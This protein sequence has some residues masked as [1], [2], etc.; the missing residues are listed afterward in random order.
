MTETFCW[1][2][3]WYNYWH[4]TLTVSAR[5]W[6]PRS[7]PMIIFSVM[8]W[9]GWRNLSKPDQAMVTEKGSRYTL[10]HCKNKESNMEQHWQ[11]EMPCTWLSFSDSFCLTP[12]TA[13]LP[14]S[15]LLLR[16]RSNATAHALIAMILIS[17][18]KFWFQYERETLLIFLLELFLY[19][20]VLL[21]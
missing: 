16:T 5:P 21:T 13:L 8:K 11:W 12:S 2:L 7:A 10:N 3:T 19:S 17:S 4:F 9:S 15:K 6:S 20:V 14:A 1:L 18:V